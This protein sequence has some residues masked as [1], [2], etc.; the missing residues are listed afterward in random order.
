[1]ANLLSSLSVLSCFNEYTGMQIL[2][3]DHEYQESFHDHGYHHLAHKLIHGKY[4][5]WKQ[6]AYNLHATY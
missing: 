2:F 1:M 3:N 5:K 4:R 6:I